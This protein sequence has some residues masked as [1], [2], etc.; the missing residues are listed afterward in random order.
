M[1][2]SA[3]LGDEYQDRTGRRRLNYTREEFALGTAWRLGLRSRA[4]GEIGIAYITRSEIQEP[5][6]VET[7]FEHEWAPRFLRHQFAWYAAADFSSLQERGWR[8]DTSLEGG[9]VT[10]ANSRAYRVGIGYLNGRPT[11]GEFSQAS[12]SIVSLFLKI[13]M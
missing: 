2:L 4:Y 9:L 11:L 6:R 13:D 12:E 10:W 3:H 1:H 5:L 8:L 7:G